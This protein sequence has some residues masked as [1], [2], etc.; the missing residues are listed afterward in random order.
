MKFENIIARYNYSQEFASFLESVYSEVVNYF[1]SE[2]IVYNAF[3]NVPIVVVDNCYDYAKENGFLNAQ[4]NALVSDN[5]LK[6][7][8]GVYLSEPVISYSD[9]SFQLA[10]IKRA[11]LVTNFNADYSK[12]TLIHELCHL[13]KGYYNEYVIEGNVLYEYGG[14]IQRCYSLG[15][16]GQ[17]VKSTMISE[18]GVGLEEGLNTIAEEDITR[19]VHNAEYQASGYGVVKAVAENLLLDAVDV[20]LLTIVKNAQLYHEYEELY[21]TLGENNYQRLNTVIDEIYKISLE[22]YSYAF[23][24]EKLKETSDKLSEYIKSD[25]IPLRLELRE[26]FL[27][28]KRA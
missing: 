15:V 7:S 13:I 9:N 4:D 21:Q 28:L 14:L 17:E 8:A 12:A 5:D 24:P 26:H 1:G 6:R 3:L 25:Y 11:V 16:D 23:E 27:G 10:G 2:E 18:I 19:K 22:I 20:D